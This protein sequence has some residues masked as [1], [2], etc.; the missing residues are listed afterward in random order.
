[1]KFLVDAQL[2]YRLAEWLQSQ[3]QDAIHCLD[4]PQGNRTTDQEILEISLV[5]SRVVITKDRDFQHSF[6]VQGKPHQLVLVSTG[7]L[8][9]SQLIKLFQD[10]LVQLLELLE[11][12]QYIEIRA[13]QLLVHG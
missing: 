8:G 5:Q 2:P 6:L 1:M 4:L 11:K 12:N 9:N 3:G 13:A 7:N 10:L